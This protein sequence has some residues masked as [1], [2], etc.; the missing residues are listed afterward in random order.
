MLPWKN[1]VIKRWGGFD[2]WSILY[3][4]IVYLQWPFEAP[5]EPRCLFIIQKIFCPTTRLLFKIFLFKFLK[6]THCNS[7]GKRKAN[8]TSY[9]VVILISNNGSILKLFKTLT[10][11]VLSSLKILGYAFE[12][13]NLIKHCCLCFKHYMKGSIVR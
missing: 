13:L 9:L 8:Q 11:C 12:Y 4:S 2:N 7:W 5:L 10:A 1:Y 6:K 3:A